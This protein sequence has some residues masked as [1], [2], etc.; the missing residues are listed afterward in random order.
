M[1]YADAFSL[2]DVQCLKSHGVNFA[3]IRA[4]HSYG[5]FDNNAI[6]SI[7]N[8][9]QAGIAN[10]DVY[11]FP[12]RGKPAADQAKGT[13]QGLGNADYGMIWVDFETNPSSGCSWASYSYDSNC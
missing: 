2:S 9:R 4:W 10:V 5:A 11:L 8:A 1:D 13:I 6:Q 12:C 3:I 7:K